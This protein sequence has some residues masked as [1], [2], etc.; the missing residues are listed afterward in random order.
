MVVSKL[1]VNPSHAAC[2][3]VCIADFPPN[4]NDEIICHFIYH[5]LDKRVV[6]G[7]SVIVQGHVPRLLTKQYVCYLLLS[8][9]QGGG[10][11]PFYPFIFSIG[12]VQCFLQRGW[13]KYQQPSYSIIPL[14]RQP[15]VPGT[16]DGPAT[17]WKINVC[18]KLRWYRLWSAVH[19]D[20]RRYH[21]LW[22]VV[23]DRNWR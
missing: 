16:R 10:T 12:W 9:L 21:R 6:R 18:A 13:Q 23:K 5:Q 11:G 20:L 17:L 14:I 19:S 8:D 22:I 1:I 7:R 2:R 4:V 15:M 3:C